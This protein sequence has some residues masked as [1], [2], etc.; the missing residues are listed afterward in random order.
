MKLHKGNH[1]LA[2]RECTKDA[3]PNKVDVTTEIVREWETTGRCDKHSHPVVWP[4][5]RVDTWAM[6]QNSLRLLISRDLECLNKHTHPVPSCLCE[7]V[8]VC[9]CR[10]QT[11]KVQLRKKFGHQDLVSFLDFCLHSIDDCFIYLE[12]LFTS[13]ICSLQSYSVGLHWYVTLVSDTA[14][15][16]F[17]SLSWEE[18]LAVAFPSWVLILSISLSSFSRSCIKVW[19]QLS[20][21]GR[22]TRIGLTKDPAL[23]SYYGVRPQFFLSIHLGSAHL[24]LCLPAPACSCK[25][26][27]QSKM[28]EFYYDI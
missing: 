22:Q 12:V 6:G 1:P 11:C 5:T 26:E 23:F 8:S 25:L 10:K 27:K 17:F 2:S 4:L 18:A 20:H 7:C 15:S 3:H 19:A 16:S 14:F 9:M 13:S 21:S 24:C 28:N